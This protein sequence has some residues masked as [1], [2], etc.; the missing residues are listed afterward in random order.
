MGNA[1]KARLNDL[2]FKYQLRNY[3]KNSNSNTNN[4]NTEN[5]HS[6]ECKSSIVSLTNSRV[7]SLI[8]Y[9]V[10]ELQSNQFNHIEDSEITMLILLFLICKK[11]FKDCTRVVVAIWH[12]CQHYYCNTLPQ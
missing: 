8:N 6:T 11:N 1:K 5:I 2:N 3:L 12:T 10:I 4:S 9:E 7:K